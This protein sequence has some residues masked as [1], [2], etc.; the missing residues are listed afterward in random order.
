MATRAAEHI[1]NFKLILRRHARAE[2]ANENHAKPLHFT[3]APGPPL[4]SILGSQLRALYGS[5]LVRSLLL[6]LSPSLSL[7]LT[8]RL[9][10]SLGVPRSPLLSLSLSRFLSR[11]APATDSSTT[12]PQ[13]LGICHSWSPHVATVLA[14]RMSQ[15][16]PHCILNMRIHATLHFEH[17]NTCHIAC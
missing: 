9:S 6:C 1:R 13:A 17:A 11:S 12:S 4:F 3:T 16:N 8:L 2:S 15:R 10:D 14:M 7:Y 5:M